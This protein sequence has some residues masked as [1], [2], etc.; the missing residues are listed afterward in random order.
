MA[1]RRITE[2]SIA[3]MV[4]QGRGRGHGV[5]Y[6]P[7]LTV[8]SFSSS[9]R[10]HR[11]LG[12]TTGRVQ[13]LFSDMEEDV[14]LK[15]DG[16]ADVLDI[17][18][19]FPLHRAETMVIADQL[20][21]AHP[22]QHGVDVVMTSDLLVDLA[23]GRRVAIAVKPASELGKRRI[24]EKLAIE[25][26]YWRRR[27]VQ[28]KVVT[29][30]SVSRAERIGAQERAQW[31]QVA[32]LQSPNAADWDECADAMLVELA[33]AA[34]GTLVE[35]CQVAER[36]HGWVAGTGMSAVRRLLARGLV[37]LDGV[38]RLTPFGPVTQLRLAGGEV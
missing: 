27:G 29:G 16:R 30:C 20:G 31:A 17:R 8:T 24:V 32:R 11:R 7:W 9:G 6:K 10:V 12:Q 3:R 19:Q 5:D 18:E 33:D 14:F 36:L 37:V 38:A 2:K 26:E 28:W 13:H 21:V 23:G 1:R 34:S 25:R 22:A 35:A 15:F 4:R